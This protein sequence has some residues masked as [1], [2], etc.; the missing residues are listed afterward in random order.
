MAAAAAPAF[1][2]TMGQCGVKLERHKP[3][4]LIALAVFGANLP[5]GAETR[6]AAR[7]RRSG[8]PWAALCRRTA[9]QPLSVRCLFADI[10]AGALTFAAEQLSDFC[11]DI[12]DFRCCL[13]PLQSEM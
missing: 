11:A 9:R 8:R 4:S 10:H 1:V 3:G 2:A 6:Q 12:V 5:F 13:L 7:S